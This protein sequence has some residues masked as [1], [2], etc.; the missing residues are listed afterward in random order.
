[1]CPIP[2]GFRDRAISLYSSKI[3]DKKEISRAV[4]NKGKALRH[5]GVWGSGC[6]D[7]A[8]LDLGTS[9]RWMVSSCPGRF[10]PAERVNGTHWLG[11]WVGPTASLDDME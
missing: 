7:P 4:S 5:E 11:G 1:M 10:T 6:I 3:V 9:W 8:F 2:N